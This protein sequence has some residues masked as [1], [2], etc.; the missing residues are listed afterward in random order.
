[1]PTAGEKVDNGNM[2]EGKKSSFL[3]FFFFTKPHILN[4][5]LSR[6]SLSSTLSVNGLTNLK[7]GF[8]T[9]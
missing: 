5:D 7:V 6:N 8:L 1:M 3:I 4:N 9:H 2:L